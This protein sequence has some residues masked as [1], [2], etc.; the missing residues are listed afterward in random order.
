M[1]FS[2]SVRVDIAPVSMAIYVYLHFQSAQ[3]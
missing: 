2:H 3:I 1:I